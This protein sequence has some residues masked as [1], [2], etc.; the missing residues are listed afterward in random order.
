MVHIKPELLPRVSA[1]SKVKDAL[2]IVSASLFL[3]ALIGTW[4][5]GRR[6]KRFRKTARAA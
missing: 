2:Y 6:E 4:L 3:A 5:L 1:V